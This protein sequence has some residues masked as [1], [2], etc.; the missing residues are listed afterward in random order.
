MQTFLPYPDFWKSAVCLDRLRL[1][2]QRVEAMQL[3][4]TFD[5]NY[6]GRWKNHPARIMWENNIEALALYGIVCC[7]IWIQR[8]YR[9]TCR[10]KTLKIL[11]DISIYGNY[12][13]SRLF[14]FYYNYRKNFLPD[15]FG[16]EEFHKSHRSN[17]LRKNYEYY[18]KFDWKESIDI[19]YV[20]PII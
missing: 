2:K 13:E 5:K 11:N 1:G 16:N 15:W 12:S 18:K 7:I 20:W 6:I 17:L 3:L 10:K 9:D 19:P 14:Y 8:G 4:K